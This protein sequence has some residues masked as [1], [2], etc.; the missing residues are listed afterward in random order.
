MTKIKEGVRDLTS[1]IMTV[2]AEGDKER[3]KQLLA[4]YAVKTPELEIALNKLKEIPVDISPM[5]HTF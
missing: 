5:Y 4:K 1:L 3:A 2:Q